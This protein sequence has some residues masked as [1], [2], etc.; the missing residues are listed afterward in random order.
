[1]NGLNKLDEINRPL[2]CSDVKREVMYIKD[3]DQWNKETK[4]KIILTN[5][6]KHVVSKNIKQITEWTKEHPNYN[7][8]CSKDS[9]KYLKIIST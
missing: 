8:S 2:H 3:N 9:D 5:A 7:D 1:M 6:L 4:D